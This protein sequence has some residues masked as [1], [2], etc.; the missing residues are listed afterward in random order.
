VT[1]SAVTEV[2]GK[3]VGG[4]FQAGV[5]V[6]PMN[7]PAQTQLLRRLPVTIILPAKATA[8]PAPLDELTTVC[9]P[10]QREVETEAIELFNSL[11]VEERVAQ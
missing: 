8:Q 3:S 10:D 2:C 7:T 6:R 4:L 9:T 11:A 5:R 1:E